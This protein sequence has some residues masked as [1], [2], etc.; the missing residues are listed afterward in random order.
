MALLRD[1]NGGQKR[2]FVQ[3][4]WGLRARF[5]FALQNP[6]RNPLVTWQQVDRIC[7]SH[8][9]SRSEER[10]TLILDTL[11]SESGPPVQSSS[12]PRIPPPRPLPPPDADQ[13]TLTQIDCHNSDRQHIR[14]LGPIVEADHTGGQSKYSLLPPVPVPHRS[15]PRALSR[16][17]I[18]SSGR[19]SISDPFVDYHKA[20]QALQHLLET[21]LSAPSPP[22][23]SCRSETLFS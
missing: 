13:P 3:Y 4:V 21:L 9:L 10:A 18:N 5:R 17:S 16:T 14:S 7:R 6:L 23:A 1:N 11:N 8:F 15:T 22:L 19:R 2:W 20:L 12:H